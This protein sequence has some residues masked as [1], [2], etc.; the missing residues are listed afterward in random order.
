LDLGKIKIA[1][2]V[3]KWL[4]FPLGMRFALIPAH[5]RRHLAQAWRVREQLPKHLQ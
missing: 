1:S 5:D 3:I 4:R 2:T